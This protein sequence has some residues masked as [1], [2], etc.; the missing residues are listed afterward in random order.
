MRSRAEIRLLC[1]L[2]HKPFDKDS[3]FMGD[4][5]GLPFNNSLIQKNRGTYLEFPEEVKVH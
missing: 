3:G 1:I 4:E 2:K 5:T